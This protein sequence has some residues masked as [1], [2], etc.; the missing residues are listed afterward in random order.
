MD[1]I[2]SVPNEYDIIPGSG[3]NIRI[4]WFGI[5]QNFNLKCLIPLDGKCDSEIVQRIVNTA[6]SL[7]QYEK[8]DDINKLT[9]FFEDVVEKSNDTFQRIKSGTITGKEVLFY[10]SAIKTAPLIEKELGCWDKNSPWV[11]SR[12]LQ[13]EQVFKAHKITFGASIIRDI[14]KTYNFTLVDYDLIEKLSSPEQ[15]EN[16]NLEKY[17]DEL[18]QLWR[19]TEL[20]QVLTEK[21]V[22][23]LK[24]FNKSKDFVNWIIQNLNK[25]NE[26]STLLD[27]AQISAGEEEQEI[28]IIQC[29]SRAIRGYESLIFSLTS[30]QKNNNKISDF[31]KFCEPL[32]EN[33]QKNPKLASDLIEASCYLSWI[34]KVKKSFGSVELLALDQIDSIKD[35]GTFNVGSKEGQTKPFYELKIDDVIWLNMEV[36]G[37]EQPLQLFKTNYNYNE[38]VE[39]QNKI[40]LISDNCQNASEKS[41]VKMFV[42]IFDRIKLLGLRYLKLRN[43]GTWLF[44]EFNCRFVFGEKIQLTSSTA[45]TQALFQKER[46]LFK[47]SMPIQNTIEDLLSIFNRFIQDW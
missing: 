13:I 4:Y 40:L 35:Y 32:W 22:E 33:S 39:L 44:D 8:L 11:K 38:L 3:L 17:T 6:E 45:R 21:R 31:L 28:Q 30:L 25:L 34:Q 27:L 15:F 24:C 47:S 7:T 5:D 46:K 10:F 14:C 9:P 36:L 41:S 2:C 43:L 37:I 12:A 16:E 20:L 19:N 23:I 26:L 29:I 42:N 18:F 1:S